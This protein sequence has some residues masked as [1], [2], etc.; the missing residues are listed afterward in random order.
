M[1]KTKKLLIRFIA[2][3]IMFV[4]LLSGCEQGNKRKPIDD[5]PSGKNIYTSEE[6]KATSINTSGSVKKRVAITFDDGPHNVYTKKIVDELT[7]Y[8]AHSTFFVVGNRV[9]GTDYKNQRLIYK[10]NKF[11]HI[12]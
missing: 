4:I 3:S 7:K 12:L 1:T 11:T 2:L 8:G 9:D 10:S 6:S 5:T